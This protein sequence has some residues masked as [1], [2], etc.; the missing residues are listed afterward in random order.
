MTFLDI[1][2][3]VF[4][5]ENVPPS[6]DQDGK[7]YETRGLVTRVRFDVL[8]SGFTITARL[9]EFA[10]MTEVRYSHSLPCP[11]VGYD[12]VVRLYAIRHGTQSSYR[13][14]PRIVA[15]EEVE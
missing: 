13:P 2:D 11:R 9:T 1:L 10:H 12:V 5:R 8:S 4:E 15:W 14:P 7:Y 3:K 6:E